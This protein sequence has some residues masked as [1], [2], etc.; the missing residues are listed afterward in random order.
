ML[1][2]CN[3]AEET[4]AGKE[5]DKHDSSHCN[6]AEKRARERKVKVKQSP[7]GNVSRGAE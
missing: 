1:L 6:E 7:F 5:V 2:R 3:F 4:T